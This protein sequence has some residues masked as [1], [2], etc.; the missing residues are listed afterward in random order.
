MS[1]NLIQV[2]FSFGEL[3]PA[4]FARVDLK[5]YRQGAATMRNFFV[6]YRAGAASTR[7]GTKFVTQCKS[8]GARLIPFQTSVLVPY[9]LEFGD[10]YVRPITFGA[11]VL[12]PPFNITNVTQAN[13]MVVT[14]PG[15]N[16][17]IGDW[18]F[19][20]GVAGMLQVDGRIF[21]VLATTATTVTLSTT[22]TGAPINSLGYSAYAGGGTAGRIYEFASPYA[23]ADLPLLKFVQITNTM[24][25]VH[26][27][28]PP[29]IL[30]FISPT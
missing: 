9:V 19:I 7:Q 3:S 27:N 28:Y 8:V 20:N 12:E 17:N 30:T 24:Y 21:K 14:I 10:H 5:Q 23:L 2:G 6:D 25:I 1:H 26:P 13:P 22:Q 15:H 11:S 18:I 16:F 29:Q 4:L